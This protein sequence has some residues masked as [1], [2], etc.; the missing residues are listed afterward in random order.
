MIFDADLIMCRL[1]LF[2]SAM[3]SRS[4]TLRL[5]S[6]LLPNS[7]KDFKPPVHKILYRIPRTGQGVVFSRSNKY[8]YWTNPPTEAINTLI[9]MI[10]TSTT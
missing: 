4:V 10:W 2:M 7:K 6:G 5:W 3:E 8:S 9:M 1:D